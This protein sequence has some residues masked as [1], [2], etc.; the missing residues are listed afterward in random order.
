M[1]LH[2]Y[3]GNLSSTSQWN[4]KPHFETR[5]AAWPAGSMLDD[6]SMP[7]LR[8]SPEQLNSEFVLALMLIVFS[9]G[10]NVEGILKGLPGS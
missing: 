6:S 10:D 7:G 5:G 3:P 4:V 8:K 2:C 9:G 1:V